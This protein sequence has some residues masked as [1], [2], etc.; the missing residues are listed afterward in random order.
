MTYKKKKQGTLY[1]CIR[2]AFVVKRPTEASLSKWQWCK[3]TQKE[4]PNQRFCSM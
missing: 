2:E 3:S 4:V 1:T